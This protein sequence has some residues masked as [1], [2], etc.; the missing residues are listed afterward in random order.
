MLRSTLLLLSILFSLQCFCSPLDHSNKV[1]KASRPES[2]IRIDGVLDDEAWTKAEIADSFIQLEPTEGIAVSQRTVVRL[3]YDNNN[4]YVAAM[5]YDSSPDSVLQEL[6]NRDEVSSLNSDA[7]RLSIDPYNTRQS[8]YTFEV[9]VSGVQGDAYDG[10]FSFDA[11]WQSATQIRNDGWSVEMRIPYS[12][13]RFPAKSEQVW[14]L[15]FSRLIRRSREF[16]QW[17]LTPKEV[18]NKMI[19]WGTLEGMRDISPPL[20]LSLTPYLS[21]YAENGPVYTAEGISGYENSYSYSGGADLKLGLDERFTLDVT[22]LPDFSQVQSDNKVKNLTAFETIYSERRPF[23]NEGTD[24][25]SKG[26]LFYSRRIGKTP[27]LFYDIPSMLE[28]GEQIEQNPDKARL[29]NATKVSG[30]T[31]KGLGIGVLNAVTNSTYATIK[32]ADG[33]KRKIETE[34]LSNYNMFVLDQQLKNNSKIYVSNS[35]V[36][37]EGSGRD[38]NVTATEASLENKKN[39]YRVRSGYSMSRVNQLQS[40][41]QSM[42]SESILSVG[43]QYWIALNKIKGKSQFGVSYEA[44]NRSYDKNDMGY[45]FKRDYSSADIYYTFYKFNPFWKHF[46][47]GNISIWG[48]R[49][50]RLS[51]NNLLTNLESGVNLFL[52]FNSN[53][54]LYTD[55]GSSLARGRDYY[56]PRVEGLYFHSPYY[57]W[58]SINFTTNYNKK[59]AFDFGSRGNIS[60]SIG[61]KALGYYIIPRVRI[62]DKWSITLSY[63]YDVYNNDLGFVDFNAEDSDHPYFGQRD[64]TTITNSLNT[65]Y[66][67]KNDMS[68]SLTARHYWSEGTYDQF[69]VLRSDGGLTGTAYE[70]NEN[71]VSNYITADL[72]YNWQFAPGSFFVV[73]YKNQI[74]KDANDTGRGYFKNFSGSIDDAQTNSISLKV[75]YYLDYQSL[76]RKKS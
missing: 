11:V 31:D 56:E 51:E 24:L 20:R 70:D 74:F 16:D 60:N 69:Y 61:Y 48:N 43:N 12:A 2:A 68:L 75:L 15:Q 72:V 5:L 66:L 6:G 63:Y 22:L 71:F 45:N 35:N 37:R 10:D 73:T 53:W 23:F 44:T 54:S 30:R 13:I 27:R 4:L 33:S 1:Y 42:I 25:F 17:S 14:G 58:A 34:P 76:H 41:E 62:S 64:I 38:A 59:L 8:G 46:K 26:G 7:F 52:L 36:M 3:M 40:N 47:Y 28:E 39:T 65:R 29:L 9:T 19:Y 21:L 18:Q 67:F 50:G 57:H 32:R 55:F 49:Q